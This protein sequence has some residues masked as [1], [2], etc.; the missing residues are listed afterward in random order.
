MDHD[1]S[2]LFG[3]RWNERIVDNYKDPYVFANLDN[4]KENFHE[5]W[6][7]IRMGF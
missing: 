5:K 1:N 3:S 6:E 7:I 4:D 2:L